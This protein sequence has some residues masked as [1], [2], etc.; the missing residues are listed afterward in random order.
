MSVLKVTEI[1]R[2]GDTYLAHFKCP[3]CSVP[4]FEA[5]PANGDCKECGA[6]FTDY[7]ADLSKASKRLLAGS[8]RG[9]RHVSKR[10]IQALRVIQGN[11]C[12]YCSCE[13]ESYHVD[14]ILPLAGGGTN[15]IRNLVIACPACNLKAGSL[16]F[17]DFT[18]KRDWILQARRNNKA[19]GC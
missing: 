19:L 9:S 8:K 14:H 7:P 18:A 4:K 6:S 10:I 16:V 2:A 1:V 11:L 15:N 5:L 17:S 13:L 3:Q 12:G